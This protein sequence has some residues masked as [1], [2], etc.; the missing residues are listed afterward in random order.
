[1]STSDTMQTTPTAAAYSAASRLA[2]MRNFA[3]RPSGLRCSTSH[4]STPILRYYR[5]SP[6]RRAT[7]QP[8]MLK[9]SRS[10]SLT[11]TKPFSKAFRMTCRVKPMTRDGRTI[12]RYSSSI[13]AC[14]STSFSAKGGSARKP[15]FC[16]YFG[17]AIKRQRV[18]MI[19]L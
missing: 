10:N 15:S 4:P 7:M 8:S 12:M 5:H 1:M 3:P 9:R 2:P 14:S 6:F 11:T 19:H 16:G 18:P 17:R 13:G